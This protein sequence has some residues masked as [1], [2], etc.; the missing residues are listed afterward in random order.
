LSFFIVVIKESSNGVVGGSKAPYV[1]RI[2]EM[3]V[4]VRYVWIG[5]AG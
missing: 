4:G 2:E 3:I 1:P 5:A